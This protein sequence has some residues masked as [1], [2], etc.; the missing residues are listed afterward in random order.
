M[1][2]III[3]G[4]AMAETEKAHWHRQ[5]LGVPSPLGI[6]EI[7]LRPTLAILSFGGDPASEVYIRNKMKACRD[8]GVSCLTANLPKD[9]I[10]RGIGVLKQWAAD[11]MVDGI[12]VQLPAP[13]WKQLIKLIPP[14]KDVDGL[15]SDSRFD[16]CTPKGVVK[17]LKSVTSLEGKKAVIVGRSEIVGKPLA[18]MLLNENCTV[19]V[20]HSKTQ[21]LREETSSADILVSAVGSPGLITADMVKDGAVVI[22]V[23][24]NRI[25]GKLT[26]DVDFEAVKEKASHITPVPG[27]VGP[28]TVAMLIENVCQANHRTLSQLNQSI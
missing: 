8:V 7:K 24:I 26:G 9:A 19:T 22:D 12:I 15:R 2:A 28:M 27:G 1:S 18:K 25:D 6:R 10:T 13:E 11:A 16:P 5:I 23:G 20:C 21:N 3:D 4:K 14:E 17:M